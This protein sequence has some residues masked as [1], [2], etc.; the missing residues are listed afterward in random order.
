MDDQDPHEQVEPDLT[1]PPEQNLTPPE[2][3]DP[4]ATGL[5]RSQCVRNQAQ[6]LVPTFGN[7]TY[8]STAAINTHL[9]HPD[10]HMDPDYVLVA[11]YIM[12]QYSMKAGMKQFKKRGENAVSKELS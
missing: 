5:R 10:A 12:T 2:V 9:V 8:E 3:P 7:K 1:E 11:H 6:R 4:G